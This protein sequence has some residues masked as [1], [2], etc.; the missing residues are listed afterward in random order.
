MSLG[1]RMTPTPRTTREIAVMIGGI[2][3]L[4]LSIGGGAAEAELSN[5]ASAIGKTANG[6]TA[7]VFKL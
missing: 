4:R 3:E 7:Q 6:K 5:N 2:A 1:I